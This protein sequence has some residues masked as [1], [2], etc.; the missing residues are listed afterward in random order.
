VISYLIGGLIWSFIM[1]HYLT[2]EM[3]RINETSRWMVRLVNVLFW[4]FYLGVLI[5]QLIKNLFE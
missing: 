3:L 1:E 2:N 5:I 4:P